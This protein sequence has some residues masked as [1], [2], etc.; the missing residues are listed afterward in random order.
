M[1]RS[2][3]KALFYDEKHESI[4]REAIGEMYMEA[5]G[6]LPKLYKMTGEG[7]K[8]SRLKR[9]GEDALIAGDKAF[10]EVEIRAE[11]LAVILFTSGTTSTSKAVMLSHG[12][13]MSNIRDMQ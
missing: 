7:E 8:L 13:I 3:A 6:D 9:A 12:N 1:E 2:R 10:S 5:G 4:V 11:A